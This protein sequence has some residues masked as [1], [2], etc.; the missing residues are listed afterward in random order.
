MRPNN[1]TRDTADDSTQ[2]A[3]AA[4]KPKKKHLKKSR[5]PA[6]DFRAIM[7]ANA[8]FYSAFSSLDM[9]VMEDVWLNDNRCICHFPGMKRLVSY[10]KIMKSFKL[11][12]REM[13]GATRRNWMV[14]PAKKPA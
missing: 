10:A 8:R 2:R 3:H 5:I 13:D 12:V 4:S 1:D 11:A 7:Q 14:L 6:D 9:T